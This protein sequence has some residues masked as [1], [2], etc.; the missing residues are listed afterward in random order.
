MSSFIALQTQLSSVMETLVHASVAELGKLVEGSSVFVFSL[1]LT[2]GE[3][4]ESELSEKLQTES[5][6]KM[7]HFATIMEVLGNEALGKIMKIVDDT[8]FPVDLHPRH[9]NV[10][11]GKKAKPQASILNIL[12][13]GGLAEEHSYGGTGKTATQTLSIESVDLREVEAP[14]YPLVLAVS[15]KDEHGQIDLGAI[16]ERAVDD[17]F[18]ER[19]SEHQ[20]GMSSDHPEK[21]LQTPCL[22]LFRPSTILPRLV[23]I[24]A[25]RADASSELIA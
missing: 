9:L 7:T 3:S 11:R 23:E 2:R 12:S 19:S 13:V 16:A 6:N 14:E 18:A 24:A 10:H 17:A 22:R 15:V 1:E 25:A 5:Q 21:I 8:K 4:A 20:Y